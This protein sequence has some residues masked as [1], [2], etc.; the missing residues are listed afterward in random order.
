MLDLHLSVQV[1]LRIIFFA[2]Y[3]IN[4]S[5]TSSSCLALSVCLFLCFPLNFVLGIDIDVEALPAGR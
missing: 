1:S 2:V 5:L 3:L 4:F